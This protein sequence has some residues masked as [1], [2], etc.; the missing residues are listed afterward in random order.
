M[1]AISIYQAGLRSVVATMGTAFTEDQ[2]NALW[3]LSTE[4]IVCFDGDYAGVAAS[5]RSLDRILPALRVGRTFKFAFLPADMDPDELVRTKGPEAF[6]LVLQDAKPLWDVLREREIDP[7]KA[8]TPDARA[9]LEQ[10]MYSIIR[11]IADPVVQTAYYRTCRI[12]LSEFF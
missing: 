4:P 2:I 11:T 8:K 1:D 5:H 12:E 6:K 10:R 9:A 3:R 7:E